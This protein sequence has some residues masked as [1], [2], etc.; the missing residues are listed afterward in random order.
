MQCRRNLE[1]TFLSTPTPPCP[2]LP[3]APHR[4]APYLPFPSPAGCCSSTG[5]WA[6]AIPSQIPSVHVHLRNSRKLL[7]TCPDTLTL[8]QH[9]DVAI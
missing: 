4:T 1:R 8:Q 7:S 6:P 3:T 5:L 9:L 2:P